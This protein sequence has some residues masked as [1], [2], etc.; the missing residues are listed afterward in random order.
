MYASRARTASFFQLSTDLRYR[1]Y[2]LLL[3]DVCGDDYCGITWKPSWPLYRRPFHLRRAFLKKLLQE[4]M[5]VCRQFHE[6]FAHLVYRITTFEHLNPKLALD[7]LNQISPKSRS[8]LGHLQF[9]VEGTFH[10]PLTIKILRFLSWSGSYLHKLT[11]A[12]P[13]PIEGANGDAKPQ[14]EQTASY[15]DL[16]VVLSRFRNSE[17]L[18]VTTMT[19]NNI[20]TIERGLKGW[21]KVE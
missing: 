12:L 1:I 15:D 8:C 3:E 14:T 2:G 16:L 6:E 5:L 11:I 4:T 7:F 17:V 20:S 18:Q 9:G 13:Y 10:V 21:E 19:S